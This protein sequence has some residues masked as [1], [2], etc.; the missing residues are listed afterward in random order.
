[1]NLNPLRFLNARSKRAFPVEQTT[2]VRFYCGQ[3]S[4]D[5]Q[6]AVSPNA[7]LQAGIK[8]DDALNRFVF[9]DIVRSAPADAFAFQIIASSSLR[10]LFGHKTQSA[11]TAPPIWIGEIDT[12]DYELVTPTGERIALSPSAHVYTPQGER[13]LPAVSEIGAA[14]FAQH[15]PALALRR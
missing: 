5:A 6:N 13:L 7:A 8:Q 11:P 3:I 12:E 1:M 14:A 15:T 10:G 9:S 2:F 4:G